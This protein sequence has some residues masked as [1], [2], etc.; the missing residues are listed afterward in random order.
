MIVQPLISPFR[1][2]ISN[3]GNF[4]FMT[5]QSVFGN[6]EHLDTNGAGF[7]RN[8]ILNLDEGLMNYRL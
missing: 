6:L 5:R 3:N 8:F 1:R 2:R 4:K 7:V